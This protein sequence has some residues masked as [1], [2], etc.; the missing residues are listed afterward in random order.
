[1][2]CARSGLEA[3]ENK[4]NIHHLKYSALLYDI[5]VNVFHWLVTLIYFIF[6]LQFSGFLP[7]A[8]NQVYTKRRLRIATSLLP[9]Y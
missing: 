2:V 7:T 8:A 5:K 4:I 9:H 3:C 6:F 1:M